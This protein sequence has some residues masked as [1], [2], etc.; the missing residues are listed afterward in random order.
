MYL[1]KI[2][3]ESINLLGTRKSLDIRENFSHEYKNFYCIN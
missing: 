1:L 2:S 3:L